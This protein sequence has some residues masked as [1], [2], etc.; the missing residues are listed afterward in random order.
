M[1]RKKREILLEV[2]IW[3]MGITY[4]L[5]LALVAFCAFWFWALLNSIAVFPN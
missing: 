5:L 2:L 3:F 1:K 4:P